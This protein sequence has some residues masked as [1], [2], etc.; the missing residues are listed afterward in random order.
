[1]AI[2]GSCACGAVR[3]A[4]EG[5][6]SAMGTCHCSRCRK[7]G[8]STIVF[9]ERGQ[10]RLLDGED[11]IE[12]ILNRPSPTIDHSAGPAE[13]RSANPCH[14]TRPSQSTRIASMT[15]RELSIH[16]TSSPKTDPVG[17]RHPAETHPKL[18]ILK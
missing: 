13:Q 7:L 12:T 5:A 10:F 15:T 3:F 1:M 14:P 9:V 2:K 17:T 16:F 4:I 6:P 8:A 18:E 11:R